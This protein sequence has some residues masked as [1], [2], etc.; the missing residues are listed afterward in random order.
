MKL[1]KIVVD[2]AEKA[3]GI[4]MVKMSSQAAESTP[5]CTPDIKG[6]FLQDDEL[7]WTATDL[8]VSV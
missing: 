6:L 3:F 7:E 1:K 4:R 8:T 5:P 2:G